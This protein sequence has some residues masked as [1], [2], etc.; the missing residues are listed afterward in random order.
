MSEN[1]TEI[2]KSTG[3]HLNGEVVPRELDDTI[4]FNCKRCGKCCSGRNDII[5]NAYDVYRIAK[6][7]NIK[8]KDVVENYCEVHHGNNSGLPIVT[9]KEDE[10]GL[11]PFLKFFL[12]EGKFGC[13][14]N[15]SKPGVCIMHPIGVAR[16]IDKTTDEINTSFLEVPSCEVHGTDVEVKVRDFIKPYLDNKDCHDAGAMLLFEALKYIDANKFIKAFIEQDEN[17][18]KE[19]F[20]EEVISRIPPTDSM[21]V[22]ASYMTYMTTVIN[23]VY[24]FDVNRDFMEQI[25]E[26]KAKIKECC[27]KMIVTFK[28]LE[29]DF[30]SGKL[31]EDNEKEMDEIAKEFEKAFDEFMETVNEGESDD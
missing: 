14:I 12:E 11:C 24:G 7:L 10:R 8:T 31:T 29:L 13:S 18:L 1:L 21:L 3:M 2:L 17:Y 5:V 20:S 23:A 26:A 16:S 25:P 28:T 19:N 27:L 9:L 6:K 30:S 15:D 4:K 22:K